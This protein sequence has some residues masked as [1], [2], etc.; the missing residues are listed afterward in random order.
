MAFCSTKCRRFSN[1]LIPLRHRC[2]LMEVTSMT[3]S[4]M[5]YW[6]PLWASSHI[7]VCSGIELKN[8]KGDANFCWDTFYCLCNMFWLQLD[9]QFI[10]YFRITKSSFKKFIVSFCVKVE[11]WFGSD[12]VG[13]G[14]QS[15][16]HHM[17][18]FEF[19]LNIFKHFCLLSDKIW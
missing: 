7:V 19:D 13:Q 17:I 4:P 14:I 11:K 1:D 18:V 3:T 5:L 8:C 2:D 10:L 9:V 16:S 12:Q 15:H 6:I